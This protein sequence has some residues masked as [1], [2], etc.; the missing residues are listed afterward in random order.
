VTDGTDRIA[1]QRWARICGVLYL[2]I[3]VAGSFAEMFVRSRLVVPGDAAA[4]ARNVSGSEA[5]FR[6]G[7]SGELLHLAFDVGVAVI[8]YALL[9][10]VHRSLALV[11]AL[12]RVA[13]DVVLA[14]ASVGHMAALRLLAGGS[15]LAPLAAD[16]RAALALLAMRLHAD[17]YA[18]SLVF[19]GFACLALGWLVRRSTFLPRLLGV[20]LA[21]GGACYLVNS[22]A[23]FLHPPTA[24]ALF[25]AILLPPFV[26]ELSLAVWLVLKGVDVERWRER[27]GAAAAGSEVAAGRSRLPA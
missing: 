10:P 24:A 22:F 19:F 12:L 18:V 27:A 7:F 20:L 4:T 16:E 13:C 5:L 26:A 11:A 6:L 9:G 3:F 23:Y 17:A 14:V 25:P 21:I 8:L 2:Y 15:A 1:P